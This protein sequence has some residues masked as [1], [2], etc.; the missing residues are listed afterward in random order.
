MEKS[1]WRGI[2]K[3]VG[4]IGGGIA[5]TFL[6]PGIGTGLGAMLGGGLGQGAA[7]LIGQESPT[8]KYKYTLSPNNPSAGYRYGEADLGYNK[9]PYTF[10]PED[11]VSGIAK[12]LEISNMLAGTAA[13]LSGTGG[14]GKGLPGN[15][16]NS[17][18]KIKINKPIY[19]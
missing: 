15:M 13:S 6:L 1:I 5:G 14:I 11:N 12:G 2:A 9:I 10:S 8:T 4:T 18:F 7:A 16:D 17:L 19:G 3:N